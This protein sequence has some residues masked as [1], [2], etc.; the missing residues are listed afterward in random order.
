MTNTNDQNKQSDRSLGKVIETFFK[1]GPVLTWLIGGGLITWS[2]G[3]YFTTKTEQQKYLD[4]FI[5]SISKLM[6][7]E[8]F[9]NEPDD[10]DTPQQII[11]LQQLEASSQNK[12]IRKK[13]KPALP[14]SAVARA[15]VLNT[16]QAFTSKNPLIN[17]NAKKQTLLKFLYEFQLIGHCND[18]F[19]PKVCYEPRI[20][21]SKTNLQGLDFS[22]ISS[23]LAG[24]SLRDT[25]LAFSNF[26]SIS[27]PMGDL[28]YANLT[29]ADLPNSDLR[30]ADL[31]SAILEQADLKEA[32]LNGTNLQ[33][34]NLCGSDLESVTFV[35][36]SLANAVINEKTIL[37]KAYYIEEQKS[38][39]VSMKFR[40]KDNLGY[41]KILRAGIDT[42][43]ESDTKAVCQEWGN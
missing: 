30:F 13:D 1:F 36:T 16:M 3:L 38:S 9:Y 42:Y 14:E 34:A 23:R 31:E 25:D 27:L 41:L 29:S 33:G 2:L 26:S 17:D 35:D 10:S 40:V 24:I 32:I 6:I 11:T 4:K 15:Y 28:K 8:E 19:N 5:D 20:K 39:K 7:E 22:K 18:I 21:L 12:P 43:P 37:E